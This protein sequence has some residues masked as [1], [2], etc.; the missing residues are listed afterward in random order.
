MCFSAESSLG[1]FIIGIIGSF[2]L[3]N[4]G[5]IKFRKE[6]YIYSLFLLYVI[7][8]QLF[9]FIF[10]MDPKN[11]RNLNSIF[12]YIAPLFNYT[13]PLLLYILKI[14]INKKQPLNT[15]TDIFVL[16]IN[17]IY[18][19]TVIYSYKNYIND[20]PVLTVSNG[21]H[22]YWKWLNHGN[23]L[24][25][26]C[27]IINIFYGSNNI[28]YSIM[29]CFVIFFSLY[30]SSKFSTKYTGEIWCFI[31]SIGSLLILIGSYLI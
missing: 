27:F 9:D 12:S 31:A 4:Y 28:N 17:I 30:V 14:F 20:K 2:L 19:I 18:F 1:T 11:K 8:M 6:N 15:Y 21:S 5:N 10:W 25:F 29:A 16:I 3:Y 23:I 7:F 24:Y 22:L 26:V 13:Q